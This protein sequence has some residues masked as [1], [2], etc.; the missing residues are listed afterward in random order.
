MDIKLAIPTRGVRGMNDLISEVFGRAETFTYIDV[1]G[2]EIKK[3]EVIENPSKDYNL[4]A[5]PLTVKMLAD[6]GVNVV[7]VTDLGPGVSQLLTEFNIKRIVIE[8]NTS[9][10][11]AVKKFLKQDFPVN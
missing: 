5:G 8:H 4:G 1:E 10:T 9:V 11:D 6:K 7:F 2:K 3:I